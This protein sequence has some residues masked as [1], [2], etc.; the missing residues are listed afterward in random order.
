MGR[1]LTRRYVAVSWNEAAR[2][3]SLDQTPLAEIRYAANAELI[4]RTEWWAWWSDAL[5]TTAIGL[6]EFLHPQGLSPDAVELITDVWASDSARPA[7]GWQVLAQVQYVLSREI[8]SVSLFRDL[9]LVTRE[10]LIVEFADA[11][12]GALYCLWIRYKDGYLCEITT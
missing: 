1:Y 3:A 4:H 12:Q 11:Q 5:L 9:Q 10:R 6:P 8:L 2:L 7:C